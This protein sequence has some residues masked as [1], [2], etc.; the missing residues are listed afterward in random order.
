MR[1][2]YLWEPFSTDWDSSQSTVRVW[3]PLHSPRT[4]AKANTS[5]HRVL[6]DLAPTS[7]EAGSDPGATAASGAAAV[8]EVAAAVPMQTPS[9]FQCLAAY[10]YLA[11]NPLYKS[12]YRNL[13]SLQY[14][15]TIPYILSTCVRARLL[16]AW[17][18]MTYHQSIS[19]IYSPS[20]RVHC[21]QHWQ[22]SPEALSSLETSHDFADESNHKEPF[23]SLQRTR[24]CSPTVNASK[25][26]PMSCALLQLLTS[27]LMFLAFPILLMLKILQMLYLRESLH[28]WLQ[29]LISCAPH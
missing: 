26:Q 16:A 15:L 21:I 23:S 12:I 2:A 10:E 11:V 14:T 22:L 20:C 6:L 19:I 25:D 17:R 3:C 7:F 8:A 18:R 27:A 4:R 5:T 9:L 13:T 24:F 28:S 29:T 1:L